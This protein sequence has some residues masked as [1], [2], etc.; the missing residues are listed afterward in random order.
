MN[1]PDTK[2]TFVDYEGM[3]R[4][5]QGCQLTVDQFDRHWIWSDQLD[6]NMVYR[7]KGRENA[8]LASIDSLLFIIQLRDERIAAL[9]RIADLAMKFADEVKPDDDDD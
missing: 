1:L 8:L 7:I 3:R 4:E 6:R 5:V 9:Q 2:L